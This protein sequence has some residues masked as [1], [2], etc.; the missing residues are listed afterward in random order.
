MIDKK[1]FVLS[2]AVREPMG[3]FAGYRDGQL[4]I[5]KLE[6]YDR[7]LRALSK[8]LPDKLT[9]LVKDGFIV[10][11]D[12]AIPQFS[13]YA[14]P[15]R[16]SDIGADGRPIIVSALEKYQ[17]LLPLK[18]ITFPSGT[19]GTFEVSSSIVEEQRTAKGEI[20]YRIDWTELRPE[21]VCFLL[22]VH[23]AMSTNLADKVS[24]D[25]F[26]E[27]LG[28]THQRKITSS[29]D[30]ITKGFDEKFLSPDALRKRG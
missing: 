21:S 25:A 24:L 17:Y 18:G 14:R 11:V 8:T 3:L 29:F 1:I 9:S 16:L 6:R 7:N 4:H 27:C 2:L 13:E 22:A 26:F 10:L 28:A 19:A 30:A 5:I 23:A 15:C 12:E 20:S